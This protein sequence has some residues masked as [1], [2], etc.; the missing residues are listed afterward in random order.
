MPR[1]L[2][3]WAVL[4]EAAMRR[5]KAGD[6]EVAGC[7]MKYRPA[8]FLGAVAH[9]VPY[10]YKFGGNPFEEIAGSLHGEHG[11]DT[12]EPIRVAAGLIAAYPEQERGHI[13]ALLLGMIS[14]IAT[15]V[16]FHPFVYYFSGNYHDEDRAK[17][18]EARRKHRLLETY[19]DSNIAAKYE[20]WNHGSMPTV[21]RRLGSAK[22][23]VYKFLDSAIVSA[24][25]SEFARS[26]EHPA[27]WDADSA[28]G[29]EFSTGIGTMQLCQSVFCSTLCGAIAR[30]LTKTAAPNLAP[31]EALFSFGRR[32]KIPQLDRAVE[33]Q[34]PVTGERKTATVD[35][36]F[37]EAVV[38]CADLF[39]AFTPWLFD[40]GSKAEFAN[41]Y[42]PSLNF[43]LP[44]APIAAAKYY[45]QTGL[46]LPGLDTPVT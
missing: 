12:F 46:A 36:L 24:A 3:H 15:D 16:V 42:G 17:R 2:V 34:N 25:V 39:E 35:H 40:R 10:Y 28:S 5:I 38:L 11:E 8:S 29:D 9:D 13:R 27:R 33:F 6:V 1:E 45:S 43:G 41:V 31:I 26:S 21:L 37:E 30:G 7:A 19:L 44:K 14:H 23:A 20:Q 4:Q 22:A 18:L 32:G